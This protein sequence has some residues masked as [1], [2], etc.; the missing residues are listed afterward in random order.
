MCAARTP[1]TPSRSS[2]C[3][4]PCTNP[5]TLNH[6]LFKKEFL[7]CDTYMPLC[8]CC[9]ITLPRGESILSDAA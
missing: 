9:C 7:L 3:E 2:R 1:S 6:Q 4:M 8:T 5:R